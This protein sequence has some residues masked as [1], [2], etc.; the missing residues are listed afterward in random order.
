MKK[1]TT[2]MM[3][4]LALVLT[5]C[6][7]GD[8]GGVAASSPVGGAIALAATIT[9]ED[10]ATRS[11]GANT[12]LQG[13]DYKQFPTNKNIDLFIHDGVEYSSY[14]LKTTSPTGDRHLEW[15]SDAGRSVSTEAFWRDVNVHTFRGFF[16]A[17][18]VNMSDITQRVVFTVSADQG[19]ST[20]PTFTDGTTSADLLCAVKAT[21]PMALPV[22]LSFGHI[23]AKVTVNLIP[24]DDGDTN[25]PGS[26]ITLDGIQRRGTLNPSDGTVSALTNTG[27]PNYLAPDQVTVKSSSGNTELAN[28]CLLPPQTLTGATISVTLGKTVYVCP[29]PN[30]TLLQA[31]KNLRFDV[32]VSND[33]ITLSTSILPWDDITPISGSAF[34]DFTKQPLTIESTSN[35]N[36]ICMMKDG[37]GASP[38]ATFKYR[39][40][41][42]ADG[43]WTEW[44][45][46][47]GTGSGHE[48]YIN[49]GDKIQIA[50]NGALGVDD[51]NGWHFYVHSGAKVYGNI[52]SLES[53]LDGSGNYSE[54]FK[55]DT[56]IT[57]ARAFQRLFWNSGGI[58]DASDLV[59]P[60]LTL[61]EYCYWDLFN[62]CGNLTAAPRL[63]PATTMAAHSYHG[64]FMNCSSLATTPE[65]PATTLAER[66]YYDM[67]YRCTSL[68]T[69][70][71]LPATTLASG[72]YRKMFDGCTALT[73]IPELP[74]TTLANECY[75]QMF[76]GCTALE[77]TPMLPAATLAESCYYQMFQGCT[78]LKNVYC[79]ATSIGASNSTTEW[80]KGVSDYGHFYGKSAAGWT[81]GVSGIP[82]NWAEHL[83]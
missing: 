33:G 5:G 68:T 16:P 81:Y 27:D 21:E 35:G 3:G 10:D 71:M 65:L 44:T 41:T 13:P 61:N 42:V 79:Y 60:A 4:L 25:L 62:N 72:C 9:T 70:P 29:I 14:Y 58:T 76:N 11:T 53:G 28:Y 80:L 54:A 56:E 36:F 66:C 30:A 82:S 31:G 8:D 63:L 78:S 75:Y 59:L 20:A 69:A 37:V 26:V 40:Y 52:M 74:A 39:K 24:N 43:A 55:S 6:T 32:T 49:T 83:E 64:M 7:S 48:V 50:G 45:V 2:I 38:T 57:N 77:N 67:F 47:S 12:E 1:I 46:F 22:P 51:D 23:M 15:Y 18:L 34:N 73:L 17:G 19:G